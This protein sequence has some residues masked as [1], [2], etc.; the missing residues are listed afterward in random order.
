MSAF[1]LAWTGHAT[2]GLL[3]L[4]GNQS[5][6]LPV[7][8]AF[9]VF[10]PVWRDGE[11]TIG[12][13]IAPG[14]YLYRDRLSVDVIAPGGISLGTPSLP[15]GETH[16][17]EHFGDTRI[18]RERVQ[19]RVK[20]SAGAAPDTVEVRYQGCAEDKVCYPPQTRVMKVLH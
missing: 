10:D 1:A 15:E 2:A 19:I 14:C 18:F 9:M 13:D 5:E 17:D 20:P 6:I 3:G 4:S 8:E 12:W 16:H 7:D 11:L